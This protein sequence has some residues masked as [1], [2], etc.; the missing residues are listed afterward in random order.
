MVYKIINWFSAEYK[1]EEKFL[2][3]KYCRK[4]KRLYLCT[5][6]TMLP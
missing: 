3:K 4:E 5:R 2:N 1:N 6:K